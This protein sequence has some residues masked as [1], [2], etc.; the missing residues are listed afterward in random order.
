MTRPALGRMRQNVAGMSRM[1]ENEM[2]AEDVVQAS[3]AG[4]PSAELLSMRRRHRPHYVTD[5]IALL[6]LV[7]VGIA[8]VQALDSPAMQ[9]HV[10]GTFLF[11]A[12]ILGGLEVT[13]SITAIAMVMALVIGTALANMRLSRNRVLSAI[14]WTYVWL[15]R[16]VPTLVLLLML[17]NIAIVFPRIGLG[18]PFGPRLF[19]VSTTTLISGYVAGALVFGLQQAGYTSE[20]IRAALLAVPR[21]QTEAAMAIGMRPLQRMTTVVLPQAARIALPAI[22]NDTINLMK[23]TSLLAFIAVPDLVYSAQLIY[24]QNY[25]IIPLLVVASL[26]Y[27]ALVSVLSLGQGLLE[28]YLRTGTLRRR[29][30]LAGRPGGLR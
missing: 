25:L 12:R 23:S 10:V 4:H 28:K 15:C 7:I 19:A 6:V 3:S 8:G 16:S 13:L 27:V 14:A 2:S 29:G 24:T 9:W 30:A 26:W 18:V 21:G 17:Y 5:A 22:A 11:D 20:V 1:E